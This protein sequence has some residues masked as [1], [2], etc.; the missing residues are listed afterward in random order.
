[1]MSAPAITRKAALLA[2]ALAGLAACGRDM[3]EL[4]P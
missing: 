2:L 1:M 3:D 4:D